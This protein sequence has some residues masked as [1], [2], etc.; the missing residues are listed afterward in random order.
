[1]TTPQPSATPRTKPPVTSKYWSSKSTLAY[2]NSPRNAQDGKERIAS[3]PAEVEASG[4]SGVDWFKR[5]HMS[6]FEFQSPAPVQIKEEHQLKDD[7]I[8]S[9]ALAQQSPASKLD[10]NTVP[11][12]DASL[13]P[14]QPNAPA[15]HSPES[16]K[17]TKSARPQKIAQMDE[18]EESAIIATLVHVWDPAV[19]ETAIN[20]VLRWART[21]ATLDHG[22]DL[23]VNYIRAFM[24]KLE[25][26]GVESGRRATITGMV[27]CRLRQQIEGL[28]SRVETIST[29]QPLVPTTT[30]CKPTGHLAA[31][32][33]EIMSTANDDVVLPA[34]KANDV[35]CAL[36]R[37]K[38][39]RRKCTGEGEPSRSSSEDDANDGIGSHPSSGNLRDVEEQN[40][41]SQRPAREFLLEIRSSI[42]TFLQANK[43]VM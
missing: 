26:H 12:K 5:K 24:A 28:R 8:A 20:L 36:R 3:R 29:P 38:H 25:D 37:R 4:L 10:E 40:F 22:D 15:R 21:A 16:E 33:E 43:P 18:N 31:G 34:C 39:K 11:T 32:I 23:G 9:P 13:D 19:T 1:M 41:D 27:T 2:Q 7:S 17:S 30:A 6:T 42:E 14:G 35:Y